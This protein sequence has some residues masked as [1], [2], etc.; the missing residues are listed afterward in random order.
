MDRRVDNTAWNELLHEARSVAKL[1]HESIISVI[2]VDQEEDGTPFVVMEFVDGANLQNYWPAQKFRLELA[3]SI[4]RQIA[5]GLKFMHDYGMV[6]R[7][8]KPTNIIVDRSGKARIADFGLAL[9][10]KTVWRGTR[11]GAIA[12][13]SRFMAPEQLNGETH[14]IDERTD[15]WGLGVII[16]WMC[17]GDYPF[18]GATFGELKEQIK[19]Q[20]HLHLDECNPKVSPELDRICRKCLSELRQDRYPSVAALIEDL[21]LLASEATAKTNAAGAVPLSAFSD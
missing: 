10:L 6:H 18:V 9:D 5:D 21:E 1:K 12:G 4:I 11:K 19:L 16:Y 15:L 14:R 8:L 7:D 17:T 3:L 20:S 2:D 13:T